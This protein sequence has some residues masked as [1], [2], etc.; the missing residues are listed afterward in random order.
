MATTTKLTATGGC[1]GTLSKGE[2]STYSAEHLYIGKDSGDSGF[3]SRITF[4]SMSAVDGIGPDRIRITG[5]KLYVRRSS[6][7]PTA[8]TVGCSRS[9]AWDASL[10]A[11]VTQ[12]IQKNSDDYQ[13]IDLAG[14][15]AAV[16]EYP[17]AWY[18]HFSADSPRIRLDSTGRSKKPYLLVTWEKAAATI[19]GDRDSAELGKDAVTFTIRPEADGETHTLAYSIGDSSGVIAEKAGNSIVWTPPLSL[20]SEIPD[21]DSAAV[22]IG[23]TVY[24]AQGNV[25]RTEVYYQTV[26]VP[27]SVKPAISSMGISALKGLQGYLLAGRSALSLAPVIDMTGTCSASI[28]SLSA[29]VTG[30]QSIHW[31]SLEET[32]PGIFTAPAAQTGALP[33]GNVTVELTVTDSRG[34][35]AVQARIFAVQ[36]YSPPVITKFSVERWELLYDENETVVDAVASD[37][38]NRIWVNLSAQKSNVPQSGTDLN[39]LT[40]A[41]IGE[42]ADGR[43]ISASYEGTGTKL[44]LEKDIAIFF[45]EVS[46]DEAW[47]F[48]ATVT[49][50]AGGTA[51][52]YSTVAPGHAAFSV[53]PDKW[54]AAIGMIS[55]G[56][57]AKPLFEV[58]EKYESR[59]Y[60]SAFDRDGAEI[61]GGMAEI[62]LKDALSAET[63]SVPSKTNTDTEIFRAEI[64]GVYLACICERWAGNATGYRSIALMKGNDLYARVRRAAGGS[65]EIQQS[66]CAVI[67]LNTGESIKRRAYQDSGSELSFTERIY[68]FA[69]IGREYIAAGGASAEV[70]VYWQSYIDDKAAA[71]DSALDAAGSSRSAFLWYTDAHWA[72]NYGTSP[73]L[74]EYLSKNTGMEKTFFGGDIA[75]TA[76]GEIE[77]LRAWQGMVGKIPNHHSVIGNHD[78]QVTELPTAAER[79]EFFFGPECTADVV[80]GTDATNGG[81]YYSID[82]AAEKTRYICLSTG[83]QR[84]NADEVTWCVG[85]L[86]SVPAGWHIVVISHL[87]LNQDYSNNHALITTPE[88][89][90]QSY[91][92]LFDGYNYRLSG[93]TRKH[94]V[95]YDFTS[96]GAKIE[97]IIGGHVHRDYDFATESGIPVILTECDAWEERDDASQA[98][99]GTTSESCVYAVVADYDAKIINVISIGRGDSRAIAIPDTPAPPAVSYT[100]VLDTV[101]WQENMRISASSGYAERE[102][103]G[104]DLTGFIPVKHGDVVRL[105][106]V[107]MA[108]PTGSSDYSSMIYWYNSAKTGCNSFGFAE[109]NASAM[110]SGGNLAQ[111]TVQGKHMGWSGGNEEDVAGYIRINAKDI[112]ESSIITVNEVIGDVVP[113]QPEPPAASY[114]NQLPLAKNPDG[115]VYNGTGY[116]TGTRISVSGGDFEERTETG[117]CTTGLIP[118]AA[119]DIIRFGNCKFTVSNPAG[120]THRLGIYD[121]DSSG[122]FI[123][124]HNYDISSITASGSAAK[125]V[126][127]ADGD[128]II[129]LTVPSGFTGVY[130]RLVA[131]EFTSDSIITVNE[132]IG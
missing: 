1:Y 59:F 46:E 79:A 33:E 27:E 24:D 16:E 45:D 56:T 66:L 39:A 126:F 132:E 20:A 62:R 6:G 64:P 100:N 99:Q 76:S 61:A 80:T 77:S 12:T 121:A 106:N 41:I 73:V 65:G 125:P 14:F 15:A 110:Y 130:I 52:Q 111:F 128:N 120:G 51:V 118:A 22:Q 2:Y 94:N 21:D 75:Q 104:T 109:D 97:F 86:G 57:R 129:Q 48:T 25:Q 98:V 101:G 72:H 7:G 115:S 31:T 29:S 36:P 30:G 42:S 23:M 68:Q 112:S 123:N 17:N 90:I 43:T 95:A 87:W 83:R 35:T 108:P 63:I 18:L 55:R 93:A 114:T 81:M 116:K 32:D 3:R 44:P 49:D 70:P 69:R 47:T 10:D 26:T 28:R 74:L 92:D 124:G 107:T 38:G 131:Q 122:A 60:G 13:V 119:G 50:A 67:P 88:D 54:G 78:D 37:V 82:N 127:D 8:V 113:E 4:P 5:M 117:W 103:T 71:I 19:S 40:W 105:K 89:Y 53:S 85:A 96:A 34:R 11:Q 91:L 9:S 84:S 58:A 102:N